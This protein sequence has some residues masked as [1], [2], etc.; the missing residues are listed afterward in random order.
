MSTSR[1]AIQLD[2]YSRSSARIAMSVAIVLRGTDQTGKLFV[3][4]TKTVVINRGGAKLL[5]KQSLTLGTRLQVAIPHLKHI[6][7]ATISWLG[8]KKGD[9]QEVGLSI[10]ETADFWGVQFPPD[11]PDF[12]SVASPI[13]S[14][15]L[16]ATQENG[17]VRIHETPFVIPD[18]VPRHASATA[19]STHIVPSS[20]ANI[21]GADKL[22]GALRQLVLAALEETMDEFLGEI[23][24]RTE[25]SLAQT[26][27]DAME[28][29]ED[30]LHRIAE[31]AFEQL[32][33]Q[34]AARQQEW[35]KILLAKEQEAE[36]QLSA[37][38]TEFE[39]RLAASAKQVQWKL[40]HALSD[41]G[42]NLAG[43]DSTS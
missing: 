40:G 43:N 10:D 33:T 8:A 5:T 3:E 35:E 1:V 7:W 14:A 31:N 12:R 34:V 15:A 32:K 24:Q 36:S 29:A 2:E 39:S 28:R 17:E 11:T 27:R 23:R 16:P 6:S 30:R 21:G 41:I 18:P 4:S 19:A 22:S 9:M 13:G 25:E 42:K 38:L 26:E 37:R 20:P